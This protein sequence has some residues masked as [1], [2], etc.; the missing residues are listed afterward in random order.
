M[1]EKGLMEQSNAA[2]KAALELYA[3]DHGKLNDG[4]SFTTRRR[5]GYP[6]H[7]EHGT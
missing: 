2:I 7:A 1:N 4:D 5:G 6:V 3:A